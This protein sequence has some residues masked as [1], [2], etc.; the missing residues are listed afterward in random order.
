M[1]VF[2]SDEDISGYLG[3]ATGWGSLYSG[4]PL[5]RY[6]MQVTMPVLSDARCQQRFG[7]DVDGATHICAG[8]VGQNKDT[9]QV[10]LGLF[11]EI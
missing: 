2:N 9:C 8:E 4:G 11:Q 1:C 3:W 10:N 7:D 6:N 5:S